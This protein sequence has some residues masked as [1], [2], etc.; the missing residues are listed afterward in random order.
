M[1]YPRVLQVRDGKSGRL[2]RSYN[3]DGM[4]ERKVTEFYVALRRGLKKGRFLTDS[5]DEPTPEMTE[6]GRKA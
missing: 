4:V 3:V 6:K 5:A 2:V 1:S